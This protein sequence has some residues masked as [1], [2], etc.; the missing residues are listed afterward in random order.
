MSGGCVTNE[1][2]C[3]LNDAMPYGGMKYKPVYRKPKTK[4]DSLRK[5]CTLFMFTLGFCCC[6]LTPCAFALWLVGEGAVDAV[7]V[8][9]VVAVVVENMVIFH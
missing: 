7:I 1:E 8:V 9:V 2:H 4:S 5:H 3:S 6:C